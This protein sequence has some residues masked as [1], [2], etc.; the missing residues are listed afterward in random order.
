MN[1]LAIL[2]KREFKQQFELYQIKNKKYHNFLGNILSIIIVLCLLAAF[3]LTFYAFVKGYQDIKMNGVS[4]LK[5]R[6]HEVL[7]IAY[8]IVI[9]IG[10]VNGMT[11]I[12]KSFM[13]DESM[14]ILVKLPVSAQTI[15][16]S[17]FIV[18]YIHEILF[19][20]LTILPINI[21]F[22]IV[23]H[24]NFWFWIMT[25]LVCL[26]LPLVELIFA[27]I[28]AMPFARIVN[29]LK[30]RYLLT[31][32]LFILGIS[33]F[34]VVYIKF[35]SVFKLW[36]ETGSIES[37][38]NQ[39]TIDL[40]SNIAK[41]AYPANLFAHTALMDNGIMPLFLIILLSAVFFGITYLIIK[42][43]FTNVLKYGTKPLRGIK[44]KTKIKQ[45][46]PFFALLKKEFVT[47]WRSPNYLFQYFVMAFIMPIM[48]FSCLLIFTEF[49]ERLIGD[50][51]N[52]ELCVF[53]ISM[54]SVLTNVFCATNISREG[55]MFNLSKRLPYS[56]Q[57]QLFIK[58]CFCCIISYI[59]VF[60]SLLVIS[61]SGYINLLEFFLILIAMF[62][63]VTGEVLIATRK[64]LNHPSFDQLENGE[65]NKEN[66]TVSFIIGTG[67][68]FSLL[69]GASSFIIS[70]LVNGKKMQSHS[71]LVALL[72]VLAICLVYFGIACFYFFKGLIKKYQETVY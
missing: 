66:T 33:L 65:V 15:F 25:I 37:I 17:K 20:L 63:L 46:S 2:T 3:T 21:T 30:S 12:T 4:T 70:F 49:I 58:V 36:F 13:L 51:W 27:S 44:K 48:T 38:F 24:P 45:S 6:Q 67:L 10:V 26:L 31:A 61:I 54:F 41:Y 14:K 71:P 69:I 9:V 28:L 53:V 5:E 34:F 35:V 42:F 39:K 18:L 7:T 55:K 52:V 68:L 59:S 72:C 19:S 23:V 32:I 22:A 50:N 1:Q 43:L 62:L 16:W 29:F 56:Y 60:I 11:K 47:I 57:K 8:L 64:D 40:I